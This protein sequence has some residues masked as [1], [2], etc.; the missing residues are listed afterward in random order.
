MAVET[1]L[2]AARLLYP[3]LSLLGVRQVKFENI[4]EV[5]A[6]KGREARILCRR[7]EEPTQEVRCRVELSSAGLSLRD[8]PGHMVSNYRDRLFSDREPC[9][10]PSADL[11]ARAEDLDTRP[12]ERG[13]IEELYEKSTGLRGRYRVLE[14]I[15]AA[16]WN[17]QGNHDLPTGGGYCGYGRTSYLYPRIFWRP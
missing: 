10:C 5:P 17:H 15:Q 14:K 8:A 1:F 3:Y 9:P 2:E 13:E 4:L 12:V 16:V 6:G 11:A 7:E